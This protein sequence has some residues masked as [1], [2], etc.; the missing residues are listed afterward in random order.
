[1]SRLSWFV[2]ALGGGAVLAAA[3]RERSPEAPPA[4]VTPAAPV[5]PRTATRG[6]EV[7]GLNEA[8]SIPKLF[9]ERG[10]FPPDREPIALEGSA[11]MVAA[12]GAG[13]VRGPTQVYPYLDMS[14][15]EATGEDWTR[16]D[17]WVRAVQGQNLETLMMVGPWPGNQTAGYTDAY[18]PKDMAA[19]IAYVKRVVERYDGDGVDDMPGLLRGNHL[20]EVDNE[21]DLHN[22]RPPR[23]MVAKANAADFE[24]P[25][26]YAA[27]LIASA[28]AI[29]AADP[30][31]KVAS[32]GFF[33]PRMPSGRAYF[34]QVF[35]VP[36]AKDA[37]DVANVHCYFQEDNLDAVDS[38]LDVVRAVLPGKALWVTETSVPSNQAKPWQT[39][40][41]QASMVA[42]IYGEFLAGGADRV[43]WHTLADPPT[44]RT[45][46]GWRSPFESNSL[47]HT[48]AKMGPGGDGAR[49][50]DKPSGALYRRMA[51]LMADTDPRQYRAEVAKGGKLLWT[52]KGWLAYWGTP[53]L[54][55]GAGAI[56]DLLTGQPGTGKAPAW[57]AAGAP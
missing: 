13:I 32:A 41:W 28:A 33:L 7:F 39:P 4:A 34:E 36:G 53:E 10:M 11:R 54:P 15:W 25:A 23:E 44:D 38:T 35:A 57:I 24:K 5:M 8:V 37:I 17:N 9:I 49:R 52:G 22:S 21:P 56:T 29:R 40:A 14:S 48:V 51:T 3:A 2:A 27:V 20:W 31:A 12:L 47:L 43:F 42:A 26:E 16:P 30:S 50:E 45:A 6:A 19:Y 55:R 46:G 18:V 1:M